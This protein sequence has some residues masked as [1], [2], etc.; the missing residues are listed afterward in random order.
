M[1]F[2]LHNDYPTA[3]NEARYAD[4]LSDM[5]AGVIAVAAIWTSELGQNACDRV[6]RMTAKLSTLSVPIAVEDIGFLSERDEYE[7]FCYKAY[8]YCSL[9]WNFNNAFAGGA[10]DDG[11]LTELGRR[12]IARM[13]VDR[14]ALDVAHLNKKSFYD[15]IE[16]SEKVLCSHT[17]FNEHVRS[18]DDRQIRALI[19]KRA[20][21]GLCAVT[22]FTD[23]KTSDE[24]QTVIDGFVQK[25]G[26]DNL[27]IGSDF[28]GTVDLPTD[29]TDYTGLAEAADGLLRRGYDRNTVNKIFYG[30]AYSFFYSER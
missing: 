12:A 10:S 22:A 6:A 23:A 16:C 3:L 14:C 19:D 11:G 7:K 21:I 13:N 30:N 8:L 29:V 20:V 1:I 4:Y 26:A 5:P 18:L 17:G 24:L 2:D 28:N 9:T 27:A 15:A 25:Y